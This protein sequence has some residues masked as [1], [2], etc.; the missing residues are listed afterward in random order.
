MSVCGVD[1]S[2]FAFLARA[3]DDPIADLVIQ[4]FGLLIQAIPYITE[5]L[6]LIHNLKCLCTA[7]NS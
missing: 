7:A 3:T 6:Q 4:A 2:S 5:R 1:R